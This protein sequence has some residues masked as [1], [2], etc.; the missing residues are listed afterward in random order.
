MQPTRICTLLL[1]LGVLL[2]IVLSDSTSLDNG[3]EGFND[4]DNQVISKRSIFGHRH[5]ADTSMN[6]GGQPQC[7]RCKFSLA[8]CCAPNICVKRRL[9]TDKCLRVKG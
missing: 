1:L 4:D 8:R 9:R 2:T 3:E 7:V 5:R 6:Q